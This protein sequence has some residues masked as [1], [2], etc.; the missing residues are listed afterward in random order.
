MH[1]LRRQERM[2]PPGPSVCANAYSRGHAQHR[3]PPLL[4]E[5]AWATVET[6]RTEWPERSANPHPD[7]GIKKC[8][9]RAEGL[10]F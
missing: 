5:P 4:P 10:D 1:V 6:G 7:M 3:A 2:T 9:F 8:T